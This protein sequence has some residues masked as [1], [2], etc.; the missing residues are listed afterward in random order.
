MFRAN[1]SVELR[2][3]LGHAKDW[4]AVIVQMPVANG[5]DFNYSQI[6]ISKDA[7]GLNPMSNITPATVRGIIDYLDECGFNY[8]GK[9]AVVLGR[10]D[11]VGKQNRYK[12]KT[13]FNKASRF[14][15]LCGRKI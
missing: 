14:N 9:S 3:L 15:C 5:I 11:I 12:Y 13:L 2:L 8:E 10:S 6:P 4:D 1:S 7:D